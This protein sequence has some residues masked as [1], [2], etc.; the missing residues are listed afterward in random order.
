MKTIQDHDH[1][2][3]SQVNCYLTCSLKYKFQ[4]IDKVPS[5][6]TP[7]PLAFG[8]AIHEAVAAFY[9]TRLEGDELRPDQMLDVYRDSWR[10]AEKVKFFNGD[11]EDSLREK[12]IQL[13]QA[14]HDAVDPGTQVVGVEEFFELPLGGLPP[15]HG[16]IDLIEQSR[17][18]AVSIVDLKTAS[19]KPSSANV[20][21]NLQL[22][23]YALGAEALG[24]DPDV[25]KLRL[26]VLMKG[27]VP[28]MVRLETLRPEEDR[29]RFISL[30]YGVWNGIE[31]EVWFP[32]QDW[33]CSQCAWYAQ[34]TEW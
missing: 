12:A 10:Q 7:A 16:Y 13:I 8:S 24:F 3:Y 33:H 14:F 4:Y 23:A 22:T 32:R 6:F 19:K 26:D 15:F 28:E 2:S 1:L 34:C 31:R 9:Q 18:G 17:E 11:N 30:I 20:Q 21:M 5:A 25:L 29:H 27:K